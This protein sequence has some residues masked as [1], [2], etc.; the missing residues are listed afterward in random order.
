MSFFRSE[1][2]GAEFW[3]AVYFG[4]QGAPPTGDMTFFRSQ[5]WKAAY[6]KARFWGPEETPTTGVG[7][8]QVGGRRHLPHD[9]I[10]EMQLL[11]A[12]EREERRRSLLR[13]FVLKTFRAFTDMAREELHWQA[14]QEKQRRQNVIKARAAATVVLAEL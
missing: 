12:V 3:A 6:W 7:S 2:W 14:F 4:Q 8:N 10:R 11:L 13:G 5:Y 1:F 9:P